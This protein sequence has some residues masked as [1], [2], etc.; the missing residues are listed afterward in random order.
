MWAHPSRA[1]V[2][3]FMAAIGLGSVLLWLPIATESG[4]QPHFVDA[5]FTSA[6][7][8]CVTGLVLS[9]TDAHWSHF[10]E[11]VIM[12]LMQAGGLGIM[13]LATVV[14]MLLSGRLGLQARTLVQTETK[15]MR[16]ADVRRVLRK[17][18][19]FSLVAEALVAVVLAGR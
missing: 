13:F 7:A 4:Q 3:G 6:S 17:V 8:V 12:L 19:V 18:L 15:T 1:L 16:P 9:D 14:A 5:L 2:G 11:V 10:G